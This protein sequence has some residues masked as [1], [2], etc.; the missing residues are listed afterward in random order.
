MVRRHPHGIPA[1]G[2]AIAAS[3]AERKTWAEGHL[4]F[5][6]PSSFGIVKSYSDPCHSGHSKGHS[7][8]HCFELKKLDFGQNAH[9]SLL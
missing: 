1:K 4:S 8:E 7:S 3:E 6:F 5:P 2:F 9:S